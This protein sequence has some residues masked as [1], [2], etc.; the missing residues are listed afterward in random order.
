MT[1]T[2]ENPMKDPVSDLSRYV[3]GLQLAVDVGRATGA[4]LPEL[5]PVLAR[6]VA[7]AKAEER[8]ELASSGEHLAKVV[9][10]VEAVLADYEHADALVRRSSI[11]ATGP[12]MLERIRAALAWPGAAALAAVKAEAWDEGK[13]AGEDSEAVRWCDH[14]RPRPALTVRNPHRTAPTGR[15]AGQ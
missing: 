12:T 5:L 10:A 9:A 2:K 3:G 13:R 1:R 6:I 14:G 8:A 4:V 15:G 11:G 7:D